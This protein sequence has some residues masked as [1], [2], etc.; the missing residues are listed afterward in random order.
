MIPVCIGFDLKLDFLETDKTSSN[1]KVVIQFL[2]FLDILVNFNTAYLEKG[3]LVTERAKICKRYLRNQFLFDLVSFFSL[4]YWLLTFEY[5]SSL[6]E[7]I[8]QILPLLFFLRV[9]NVT[10]LIAKFEDSLFLL[11]STY[12]KISFLKLF[13]FVLLFAHVSA[14]MWHYL[15]WSQHY[16]GSNWLTQAGIVDE[17]WVTRYI[18][19]LYYVVVVMNTIGFGDIVPQNN[20]ERIFCIFFIY[21]GCSIFAYIINSIGIILQNINKYTREYKRKMYLINDYMSSKNIDFETR[22]KVRNYLEHIYQEEKS[23]NYEE[24]NQIISKL[25]KSLKHK[26][27]KASFYEVLKGIPF[28]FNNFS[29]YSLQKISL[30]LKEL[31][32]TP[33]EVISHQ[34]DITKPSLYIIRHGNVELYINNDQTD[35]PLA[36]L[37]NLGHGSCFGIETV[38]TGQHQ[39]FS[40][41][42]STFT[43]VFVISQEAILQILKKN[44]YDFEVWCQI[45]DDLMANN[46]RKRLHIQCGSCHSEEHVTNECPLLNAVWGKLHIIAKFNFCPFQKRKFAIRSFAKKTNALKYRNN[47]LEKIAK[48]HA[49]HDLVSFS[50][51]YPRKSSSSIEFEGLADD[52]LSNDFSANESI[53]KSKIERNESKESLSPVSPQKATN[54]EKTPLINETVQTNSCS[55]NFDIMKEYFYYFTDGN[56]WEFIDKYNKIQ[57]YQR[58]RV[59]R[60]NIIQGS[61]VR[62]KKNS[63]SPYHIKKLT[64]SSSSL[65]R[66]QTSKT[67][68]K[69]L[70]ENILNKKRSKIY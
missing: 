59:R 29:D 62:L 57:H 26:L 61:R 10:N 38:L 64:Q 47:N 35:E 11:E 70:N 12:N 53:D 32:F 55:E 44:D 27:S 19:S 51:N 52:T 4:F 60:K 13:S 25:S 41:R 54:L 50:S 6:N 39:K 22:N 69:Q 68:G 16:L 8:N 20:W 56:V 28:F 3:E 33:G 9:L 40:A 15:G 67:L 31:N 17:S 42:S 63:E 34:F 21:F 24:V 18:Y 46:N 2:F 49:E 36:V 7:T 14:C 48:F 58:K 45:R 1:M 43:T 65:L 66:I 37:E 30:E 5:K 23:A